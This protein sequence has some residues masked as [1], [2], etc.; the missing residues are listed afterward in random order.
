MNV[1][2]DGLG[3]EVQAAPCMIL[4][5]YARG[6]LK[7]LLTIFHTVEQ[8]SFA[9]W[10]DRLLEG[11]ELFHNAAEKALKQASGVALLSKTV[12]ASHQVHDKTT[13][14][15]DGGPLVPQSLDGSQPPLGFGQLQCINASDNRGRADR[16]SLPK[17]SRQGMH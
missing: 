6:N 12:V 14:E 8:N 11:G 17:R 10:R 7:Q 4:L 5:S 15:H 9:V 1:N 2:S 16:V 3:R 13:R